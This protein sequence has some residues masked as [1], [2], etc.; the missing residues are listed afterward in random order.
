MHTSEFFKREYDRFKNQ[1]PAFGIFFMSRPTLVITDP[2]LVKDIL[3]KSFESFHDHGF[4][5]NEKADPLSK[6]LFFSNG[7]QWK[8]LRAKL[9]PTFTSGRMK[10]M[11][12]IVTTKADRMIDYLMPFVEKDGSI[13]M[14]EILSSYTTESIASVA[15]GLETECLGNPN[16]P[17][18]KIGKAVFEPPAWENIKNFI[19]ISSETITNLFNLGFNSKETTDFFM[20]TVKD[21]MKYRD[22]KNYER[23]DFFQLV[24]KIHKDN[25]MTF[26][27]LAANCFVFFLAG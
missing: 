16:S 19:A 18:R 2:D 15:F 4:Y 21:T 10:L 20:G 27:E 24:M 22:E 12:P 8:E 3:V 13:E 14:K 11:F 5:V 25:Q 17:F 6:N 1:T 7:Q 9:S 23:N 26:N